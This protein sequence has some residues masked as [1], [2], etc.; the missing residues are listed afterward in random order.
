MSA[1]MISADDHIDLGYLPHDLWTERLPQRFR[2][3]GPHVEDR[4][5]RELW[6]C[7]DKVW[8]EWRLGKWFDSPSR[9]RV[10]LDRFPFKENP[11]RRPI[12]PELRIQDMANDGVEASVLF[13]PIF[14]MRTIDKELASA[15]ISAYN[16]WA[17]EFAAA[18]PTQLISVAQLFPDDAEASTQ[19][20]IRAAK[21]GIKQI[22]FLVGTVTPYMYQEEWDPFWDAAEETGTIV[23]YHV[24]GVTQTGSFE[25]DR[26]PALTR[27]AAFGMGLGNGATQFFEP[28]VGMFTYG[29]LERHPKLKF[30]LGESGT[31]WIPAVVQEMDYRVNRQLETISRDDY[32]LKR[33][34]SEIFREQVWATYQQDRV[35]LALVDFFGEDKMMWA[36]DYPHPDST[37]PDSQAIVEK[38]T[39]GLDPV[40]K[41]RLLR[42]NARKLYGI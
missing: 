21:M 23:S 30:V 25:P 8:S 6:I 15:M 37:W 20:L 18:A 41:E 31:G 3:R 19:E 36:S 10:A 11:S 16:D 39:A 4:D 40:V 24:G 38:E 42:G 7:D 27:P 28:F 1:T 35:G 17:A 22:N 13:P 26:G 32:P 33:L 12:T 5:G 29:V 2:E 14:G 9:H 34:P